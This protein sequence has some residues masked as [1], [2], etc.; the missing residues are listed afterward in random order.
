MQDAGR[1][2]RFF[3]IRMYFRWVAR[4]TRLPLQDPEPRSFLS[5]FGP[6]LS[7][8]IGWPRRS[9]RDQDASA[10]SIPGAPAAIGPGLFDGRCGSPR[11]ARA[12][13]SSTPSSSCSGIPAARK[14]SADAAGDCRRSTFHTKHIEIS[15][16][17]FSLS[18]HEAVDAPTGS[19]N[20]HSSVKKREEHGSKFNDFIDGSE[21]SRQED[22]SRSN[23]HGL[24]R[25]S[26]RVCLECS[27]AMTG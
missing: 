6:D 21:V 11:P 2:R 25:R 22:T 1:G 4:I 10:S 16:A 7:A 15:F 17:S 8:C 5:S 14:I 26:L 13:L 24:S 18:T 23:L 19:I 3:Q 12:C 27:L 20:F 9:R